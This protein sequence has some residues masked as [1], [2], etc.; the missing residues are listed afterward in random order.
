[1]YRNDILQREQPFHSHYSL[2]E[3]SFSTGWNLVAK[4]TKF[5]VKWKLPK[6]LWVIRLGYIRQGTT[7]LLQCKHSVITRH[8]HPAWFPSSIHNYLF[9]RWSFLQPGDEETLRK[10]CSVTLEMYWLTAK[11]SF[12]ISEEE[13]FL[14]EISLPRRRKGCI[15]WVRLVLLVFWGV[16]KEICSKIA[17]VIAPL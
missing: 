11:Y 8:L 7:H 10:H 13:G 6:A 12:F 17:L 4:C 14:F 9:T 1:M 5:R 2:V 3:L 16:Y 15:I